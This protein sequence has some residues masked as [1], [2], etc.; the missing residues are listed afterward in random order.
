[1]LAFWRS[2]ISARSTPSATRATTSIVSVPIS[3]LVRGWARRLWSH[4]GSGLPRVR[5]EHRERA[6]D[7]LVTERLTRSIPVFDPVVQEQHVGTLEHATEL[8]VVGAGTPR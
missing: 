3:A 8:A 2:Q 5:A 1:M 7:A 4:A 6:A